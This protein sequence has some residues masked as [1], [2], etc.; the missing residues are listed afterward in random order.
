M[1][2]T[3]HS[4]PAT[5]LAQKHSKLRAIATRTI[6]YV[7]SGLKNAH[8][9][10]RQ[11]KKPWW[12]EFHQ[13]FVKEKEALLASLKEMSGAASEPVTQEHCEALAALIVKTIPCVKRKI[14]N[15]KDGKPS[16]Q[17]KAFLLLTEIEAELSDAISDVLH[18]A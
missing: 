16:L 7:E 2:T 8:K 18:P 10:L 3:T 4:P 13:I 5:N 1:Q 9:N 6:P 15:T 12:Q 17:N 14:R 11:A